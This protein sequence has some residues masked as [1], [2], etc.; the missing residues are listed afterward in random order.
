MNIGRVVLK[1]R[2][3]SA[4]VVVCVAA[5]VPGLV[6]SSGARADDPVD[7]TSPSTS[8]ASTDSSTTLV[9]DSTPDAT[10]P[11]GVTTTTLTTPSVT[12]G[13]GGFGSPR[14]DPDAPPEPPMPDPSPQVR[15]LLA[16]LRVQAATKI[17]GLHDL[18]V[19][20]QRNI[21]QKVRDDLAAAIK[22]KDQ[23]EGE[24][25]RAKQR[26]QEAALARYMSP[27]ATGMPRL[28]ATQD[29]TDRTRVVL[30]DVTIEQ[31]IDYRNAAIKQ[32]E[33]KE[34]DVRHEQKRVRAAQSVTN[35]ARVR[36]AKA[37]DR[38]DKME[39][40]L[41]DARGMNPNWSLPIE[42]K[43]VFTAKEL[44]AWFQQRGHGSRA[45]APIAVL[46]DAYITEGKDQDIRGDM[47]FAQSVLE[48]GSFSNPDTIGLNNYAGI[49]HCDTCASGFAF[50]SPDLG[51]R[52][53]IQLLADYAQR[54]VKLAHPLVDRRLHGP[55]GCC[56]TW[57]QLTHTWATNGNYGPKIMGVYR[58]MLYWLVVHRGL[59]PLVG[60]R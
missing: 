39:S 7:T 18:D 44:A 19:A 34:R 56:Q 59:D 41:G 25:L 60:P 47:A 53:Q 55:T 6:W 12:A 22:R 49:G 26:L 23:A 37:Q 46:A 2:S 36:R 17:V 52:A 54:G 16:Q 3:R 11:G 8:L 24:L 35:A 27:G 4:I 1:G 32:L 51:V 13:P 43:S 38:L 31:C 40:E 20:K 14:V 29:T 9:G 42:G 50:A 21:E 30:A 10:V 57:G 15:I 28:I 33:K 5:L 58:E 48:T 45:Q